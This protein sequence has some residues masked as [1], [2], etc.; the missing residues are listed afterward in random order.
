MSISQWPSASQLTG[1]HNKT[2]NADHIAKKC[3]VSLAVYVQNVA[4]VG[5][6]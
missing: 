4:T 6:F 2:G 3:V 1:G 5:S